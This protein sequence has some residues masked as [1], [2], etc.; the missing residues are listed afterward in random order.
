MT[1]SQTF[2]FLLAFPL[3]LTAKP[4]IQ[5]EL[6]GRLG[7]NLFQITAAKSLALD[8]DCDLIC[9]DLEK[10]PYDDYKKHVLNRISSDNSS[11]SSTKLYEYRL[12]RY[13]PIPFTPNMVLKG[14]FFSEKYFVKYKSEILDLFSPSKEIL[15][16]LTSH[17]NEIISHPKSVAVHLRCYYPYCK[18]PKSRDGKGIAPFLGFKYFKRAIKRLPSDSLFVIFSDNIPLC[19]QKL[20]GFRPN[21]IFMENEPYYH[22]FYLMSMCKNQ[23]I[24]NSTFSWWAAYL[25]KNPSKIVIAPDKWFKPSKKDQPR[26]ITP[27]GW[28][29]QKVH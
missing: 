26:D 9:P 13:K 2:F 16:Y 28:V 8:N 20:A 3:I 10:P 7:N 29:E 1:L 23:I 17:F 18:D 6:Y 22:D 4:Y 15:D 27:K 5:C 24:S 21:M 19:K 12:Y 14:F 11:T 25:N